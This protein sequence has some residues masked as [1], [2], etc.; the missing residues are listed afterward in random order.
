MSE[1]RK[2]AEEALEVLNKLRAEQGTNMD[3][4]YA[5][6]LLREALAKPENEPVINMLER[7][8]FKP[9]VYGEDEDGRR[10][11]NTPAP[12][13]IKRLSD[14]DSLKVFRTFDEYHEVIDK[15]T[16]HDVASAIMDAMEK[17]NACSI[18]LEA[19]P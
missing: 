16:W 17:L 7:K 18:P 14:T 2:A 6:V 10:V 1:L 11:L 19:N 12:S 9:T 8:G 5:I 13:N 15:D 3:E 4:T